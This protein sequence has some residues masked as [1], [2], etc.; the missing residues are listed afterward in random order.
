MIDYRQGDAALLILPAIHAITSNIPRVLFCFVYEPILQAMGMLARVKLTC[1]SAWRC[2]IQKA[3]FD[4]SI[5]KRV[6]GGLERNRE[7]NAINLEGRR[8]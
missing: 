7:R 1:S 2:G 4:L 6:C 5:D 3:D 8:S